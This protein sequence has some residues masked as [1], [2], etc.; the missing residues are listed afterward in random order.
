MTTFPDQTIHDS[1]HGVRYVPFIDN[2]I[3]GYSVEDDGETTSGSRQYWLYLN[4]STGGDADSG[5][6]FLYVGLDED[7]DPGNDAP[8]HFY[9]TDFDNPTGAGDTPDADWREWAT[10][11][12]GGNR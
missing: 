1:D 6:I 11:Q 4:P 3:V 2:G 7:P 10:G 12:P 8:L 9:D 5:D